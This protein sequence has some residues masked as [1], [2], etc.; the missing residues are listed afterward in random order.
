M[1]RLVRQKKALTKKRLQFFLERGPHLSVDEITKRGN[2]WRFRQV[3]YKH[4][5]KQ[6][7]WRPLEHWYRPNG[8]HPADWGR[9]VQEA[10]VELGLHVTLLS[11]KLERKSYKWYHEAVFLIEEK[12]L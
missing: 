4:K 6:K 2:I 12:V 5:I 9:I 8:A 1:E 10:L 11:V 3:V 7:S